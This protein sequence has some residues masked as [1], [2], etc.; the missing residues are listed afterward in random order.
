[1]RG[2]KLDRTIQIYVETMEWQDIKS[3]IKI[4]YTYSN[5]I[6]MHAYILGGRW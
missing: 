4:H 2:Q 1:M 3:I 6:T 5:H